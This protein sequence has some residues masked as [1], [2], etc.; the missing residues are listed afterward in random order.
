MT[1]ELLHLEVANHVFAISHLEN[2]YA[3]KWHQ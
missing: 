1:I 2:L 3:I